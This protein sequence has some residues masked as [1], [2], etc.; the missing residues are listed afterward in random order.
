MRNG[1]RRIALGGR[2][3]E[4]GRYL[5]NFPNPAL[6][7]RNVSRPRNRRNA[8]GRKFI[9]LQ[10]SSAHNFL[11]GARRPLLVRGKSIGGVPELIAFPSNFHFMTPSN[12]RS[13]GN[14]EHG[15]NGAGRHESSRNPGDG[16]RFHS[17]NLARARN[18]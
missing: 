17:N 2:N 13:P 1:R 8:L 15:R 4:Q 11:D 3:R 16:S 10:I 6:E 7:H 12:F 5:K 9:T 18:G 14:L